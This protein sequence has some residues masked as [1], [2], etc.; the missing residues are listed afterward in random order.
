MQHEADEYYKTGTLN[1]INT[2]VG[3]LKDCKGVLYPYVVLLNTPGKQ[4][5]SVIKQLM[6]IIKQLTTKSH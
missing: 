5:K 3:Y 1:G 6:A 4:T 2:R